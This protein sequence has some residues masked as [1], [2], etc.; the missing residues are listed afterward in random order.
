MYVLAKVKFQNI[1]VLGEVDVDIH[2]GLS[3]LVGPN[4][5]GKS[6]FL[7]GL[8]YAL[9]GIIDGEYGKQTSLKSDGSALAGKAT[10]VLS[11]GNKTLTITRG[12]AASAASPDKL[13]I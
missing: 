7:R 5:C 13:E 1:G 11:D 6:T 8:M 9:T 12:T 2:P 4:G 10:V 3:C